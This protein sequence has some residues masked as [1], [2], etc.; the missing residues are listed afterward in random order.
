[1]QAGQFLAD[2][3][4]GYERAT[5]YLD[6]PDFPPIKKDWVR[7]L[8]EEYHKAGKPFMLP[9]LNGSKFDIASGIGIFSPDTHFLIP[10]GF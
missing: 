3:F 6:G 5:F 4:F 7:I 9:L 2:S 1:M 8:S 10:V